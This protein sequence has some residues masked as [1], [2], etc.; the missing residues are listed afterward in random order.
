MKIDVN[1]RWENALLEREEIALSIDHT[2]E[3]T[4]ST[5]ALRKQVA[6]ELDLDPKTVEV[7]HIYSPSGAARS[8]AQVTVHGEPI[9]DELPTDEAG[10]EEA[11]E[12]QED[13]AEPDG[14][15]SD[16]EEEADEKPADEEPGDEV[17]E[18]GA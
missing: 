9:M 18:G 1:E 12:E 4:P 14:D 15:E 17:K 6:A 3:A 10:E 2:G 5:N 8:T 7:N 16:A 11:S 13:M